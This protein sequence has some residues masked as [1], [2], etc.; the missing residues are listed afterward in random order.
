MDFFSGI[1]INL[2]GRPVA[3]RGAAHLIKKKKIGCLM[4][5]TLARVAHI[6]AMIVPVDPLGVNYGLD[7]VIFCYL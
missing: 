3:G 5:K 7:M 2:G 1:E 6:V 4:K